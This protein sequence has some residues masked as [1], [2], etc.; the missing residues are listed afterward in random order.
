MLNDYLIVK[1]SP[2][3][4]QENEVFWND[5]RIT[6][7]TDRLFRIEKNEN[8]K[9][10]DSA[11][12]SVWFRDVPVQKFEVTRSEEKLTIK[13]VRAELFVRKE[14][15]DCSV[16]ICGEEKLISNDYNLRG[17]YRTLDV[18]EGDEFI[19]FVN[20]TKK[21]IELG[22]GVCSR[23]GVAYFDDEEYFYFL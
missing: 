6:V 8:K 19:D 3:A 17:T 23:N 9:F 20:N 18:C 21:K 4:K 13:T 11:T 7:L 16:A 2:K 12:R 5:Y 15:K 14:L 10:R 22:L 1:V